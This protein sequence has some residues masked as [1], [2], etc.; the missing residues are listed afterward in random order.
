M[1]QGILDRLQAK[2]F[3]M[4]TMA[5]DVK[6]V[7][8]NGDK[9]VATVSVYPKAQTEAAGMTMNYELERQSGKWVV[10][11]RK[12][13]GGAPHGETAP[14]AGSAMP[15]GNPHGGAMPG[16][17]MPGENPHGGG[18]EMPSPNDLPPAGQKK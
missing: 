14:G 12:D 5:L 8:F 13:A 16:G 9:A 4:S 1:R 17:A 2:Q 10:T 11:D 6:A 18:A 15:G 7:Q 3:N